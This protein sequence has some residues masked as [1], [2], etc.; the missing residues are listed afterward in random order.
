MAHPLHQLR[1]FAACAWGLGR[2]PAEKWAIFW[3]LTKN[4]RV[5]LGLARY[6]PDRVYALPTRH[7]TLHLRDNFGDITNVPGLFHRPVYGVRELAEEGA[8]L[9][10]G[11]NIG[12]FSAWVDRHN[13]GRPIYCFEPLPSN[14]AMIRLN[15][16]RAV[17]TGLGAGREATTVHFRVDGHG[18]MATTIDTRWPTQ[19]A[20]F[21]VVPIDDFARRN[22]IGDVAVMKI[23][24][25]GMELDVL[26]GAAETLRRTHRVVM[27]T[28][29]EDRHRG[30][31][32]RLRAAGFAIDREEREGGTGMILASRPAPAG[33]GRGVT[34]AR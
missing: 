19:A 24:T 32:E 23:D 9:D 29:G 30:A 16:P 27:E 31:L 22:G 2:T 26:D 3:R 14:T 8:V 13:P 33:A 34:A 7:G 18:I 11:A 1:T 5:R 20:S 6:H 28:H 10:V 12:L 25:E 21:D 17:A 4:V 15:C